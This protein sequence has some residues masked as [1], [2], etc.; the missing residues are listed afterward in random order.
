VRVPAG[1]H[2]AITWP[3]D[4]GWYDVEVT[5]PQDATFRRR[6]T[7]RLETGRPTVTA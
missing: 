5:A 7:G 3:T 4:R 1:A 2:R 6:L